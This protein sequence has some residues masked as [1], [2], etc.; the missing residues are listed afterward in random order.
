M[1]KVY[2]Q[3]TNPD[4]LR[5]NSSNWSYQMAGNDQPLK[6]DI[7]LKGAS[8][9]ITSVDLIAITN[10]GKEL[11][12]QKLGNDLFAYNSQYDI[13]VGLQYL[14][15]ID[16]KPGTYFFKITTTDNI[17]TTEPVCLGEFTNPSKGIDFDI[18]GESLEVY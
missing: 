6:I 18:I 11:F 15:A 4:Y 1:L 10:D 12:S 9:T 2:N 5:L 8:N 17:Y 13:L 16:I 3:N 7:F 14:F